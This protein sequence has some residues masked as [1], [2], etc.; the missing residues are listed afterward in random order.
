MAKID[1]ALLKEIRACKGKRNFD[2]CVVDILEEHGIDV[3]QKD[4]IV[5]KAM[6]AD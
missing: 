2:K 1:E 5:A 6:K 3:E 4:K